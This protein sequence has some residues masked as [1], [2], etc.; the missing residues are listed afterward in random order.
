[1][2]KSF[3]P[4]LGFSLV[5]FTIAIPK[6]RPFIEQTLL[7]APQ[8]SQSFSANVPFGQILHP[9]SANVP[10]GQIP[11]TFSINTPQHSYSYSSGNSV[12]HIIRSAVSQPTS[13]RINEVG[14]FQS[15]IFFPP[16]YIGQD[17]SV[18]PSSYS[19][20][21]GIP[22]ENPLQQI[23]L[24]LMPTHI[25]RVMVVPN[26]RLISSAY[27]DSGRVLS[28][29]VSADGS[30]VPRYISKQLYDHL[31]AGVKSFKAMV[32]LDCTSFVICS[33]APVAYPC[34]AET[35]WNDLT[36]HCDHPRNAECK[37]IEKPG[38]IAEK[39]SSNQGQIMTKGIFH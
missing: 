18:S 7:P 2:K 26:H 10:F 31:C 34:P 33:H 35:I 24:P 15:P 12:D 20:S 17:I 3:F 13:F 28:S 4:L 36:G 29:L 14:E 22:L 11:R 39:Y 21:Y 25:E 5:A 27:T 1:M 37:T 23:G 30:S 32:K 16:A 8:S 19:V 9:V 6:G 38:Y